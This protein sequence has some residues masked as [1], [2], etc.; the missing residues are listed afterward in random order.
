MRPISELHCHRRSWQVIRSSKTVWQNICNRR[1]VVVFSQ[2]ECVEVWTLGNANGLK[3]YAELNFSVNIFKLKL[4]AKITKYKRKCIWQHKRYWHGYKATVLKKSSLV[5][6]ADLYR[7]GVRVMVRVSRVNRVG[8]GVGLGLWLTHIIIINNNNIMNEFHRD[9]SLEQNFR[10][11]V[12][13]A[14]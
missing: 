2:H 8:L 5:H 12:T 3:K 14:M 13:Y 7:G 6:S 4:I 1:R 9:A 11:A 10:A